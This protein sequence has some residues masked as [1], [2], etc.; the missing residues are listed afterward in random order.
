MRS[1]LLTAT[2]IAS[3]AVLLTPVATG[4]T[5]AQTLAQAD[6]SVVMFRSQF[7][8][9]G[10]VYWLFAR[11]YLDG[12]VSLHIS[13]PG[14]REVKDLPQLENEF[15]RKIQQNP[16]LQTT[17]QIQVSEGNGNAPITVYRLNVADPN[18]PILTKLSR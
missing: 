5:L 2:L 11:R 15:I 17:Y 7:T 3:P 9:Q 10:R 13:R 16:R 4:Q 8:T 6:D 14:Y 18:N 1:F 12:S